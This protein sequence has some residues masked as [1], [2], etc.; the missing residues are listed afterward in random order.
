VV[1]QVVRLACTAVCGRCSGFMKRISLLILA[2]CVLVSPAALAASTQLTCCQ[3]ANADK[4][5]CKHKCCVAAHKDSKS[6][7]K[8]NPNKEDLKLTKK[9]DKDGKST[10]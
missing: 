7:T 6:C 2:V 4:Q 9:N 10:K 1:N 3:K 8:C 5:E